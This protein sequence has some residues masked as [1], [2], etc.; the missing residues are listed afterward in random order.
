LSSSRANRA[1]IVAMIA[2]MGFYIVNDAITK[3]AGQTYPPGEVLV[4]RSAI[5]VLC[6]G[7]AIGF[8]G[9]FRN[10]RLALRGASLVRFGFESAASTLYVIT[11]VHLPLAETAAIILTVPLIMTAMAVGLFGENVGWRRW[12]AVAVGMIGALIVV[13][14]TPGA[15]DAWAIVGFVAAI[16]TAGRDLSTR[17]LD[18]AIPT[19]LV[20]FLGAVAVLLSSLVLGATE[21]W[22]PMAAGDLGW[23]AVAAVFHVLGSYFL[24]VASRD[25]DIAVIAPF[26]YSLLIWAALAGFLAF[27]EIPDTW[28]LIGG[29]MIVGSGVYALHRARVRGRAVATTLADPL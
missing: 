5:I 19:L 29:A 8:A 16:V 26:R 13:K 24:I 20:A 6:L 3:Y 7:A 10:I 11:L 23:L 27:A 21:T 12:T 25:G 18:P 17:R 22:P 14:P 9:Q 2:S 4:Y 28:A 1:G 15:F